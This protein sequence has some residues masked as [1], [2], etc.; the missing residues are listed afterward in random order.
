M[1]LCLFDILCLFTFSIEGGFS[2]PFVN[3][4]LAKPYR[5]FES[6]SS[7]CVFDFYFY[8]I[9]FLFLRLGYQEF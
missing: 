6:S 7:I 1:K 2:V 8:L 4:I 9:L 3:V 5:V